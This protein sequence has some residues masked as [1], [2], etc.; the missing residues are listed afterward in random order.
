[1]TLPQDSGSALELS[2]YNPYAS[3]AITRLKEQAMRA[4]VCQ[5]VVTLPLVNVPS[6]DLATTLKKD[7]K[8]DTCYA[9]RPAMPLPE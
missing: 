9:R 2:R 6:G 4:L 7:T 5:S 8:I 1:M 3:T